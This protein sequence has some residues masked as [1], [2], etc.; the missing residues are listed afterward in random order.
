VQRTLTQQFHRAFQSYCRLH[1][2]PPDFKA[3]EELR[4]FARKLQEAMES[5]DAQ[6]NAIADLLRHQNE[7]LRLDV[8]SHPDAVVAKLDELVREHCG[9]AGLRAARDSA[10]APP[11]PTTSGIATTHA[12][13]TA[14]PPHG[15]AGASCN[16][17]ASALTAVAPP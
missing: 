12:W 3:T 13:S 14:A 4:E 11:T 10:A 9:G 7:I 15:C 6:A 16:A 1:N 17:D 5:L 8:I 2:C